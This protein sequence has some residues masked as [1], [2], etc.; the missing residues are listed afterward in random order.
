MSCELKKILSLTDQLPKLQNI[1]FVDDYCDPVPEYSQEWDGVLRNVN[2]D[3]SNTVSSS[4]KEESIRKCL[5]AISPFVDILV[6]AHLNNV[7]VYRR[8]EE[9]AHQLNGT[10]LF[11]LEPGEKIT[12]IA[13]L[14]FVSQQISNQGGLDWT[15]IILGFNSG[16]IRVY[17]ESMSLLISQKLYNEPVTCI[18]VQSFSSS[19]T[20]G[21]SHHVDGEKKVD[22]IFVFFRSTCLIIEGFTFYQTLRSCRNYLARNIGHAFAESLSTPGVS[23]RFKKWRFKNVERIVDADNCGLQEICTYDSLANRSMDRFSSLYVSKRSTQGN[24]VITSGQDPFIS[25]LRTDEND[26]STILEEVTTAVVNKV[27]NFIPG[28]L[29]TNNDKQGPKIEPPLEFYDSLEL[30]D[31]YRIGSSLTVSPSRDLIAVCDNFGRVILISL[32]DGVAIRMWKGYRDAQCGWIESQENPNDVYSRKILFLCIYAPKRG[33]LEIWRCQHGPRVEAF[34]VG[35]NCRL[36][37]CGYSMIGMNDI[38]MNQIRNNGASM[39]SSTFCY[40]F[41]YDSLS[42]SEIHAPFVCGLSGKSTVS[43]KDTLL[44]REFKS[45]ATSDESDEDKEKLAQVANLFDRMKSYEVRI[46]AILHVINLPNASLVKTLC[47]KLSKDLPLKITNKTDPKIQNVALKCRW[48]D[49]LCKLHDDFSFLNTGA[50]KVAIFN[51]VHK[52]PPDFEPQAQLLDWN[53]VDYVRCVS[54]FSFKESIFLDTVGEKSSTIPSLSEFISFFSLDQHRFSST[55]DEPADQWIS[56][57]KT[58]SDSE[59]YH[60]ISDLYQLGDFFLIPSFDEEYLE[61]CET[62]L[63]ACR[64]APSNILFAVFS[65]W[66]NSELSADW[67][68]WPKFYSYVVKIV[69][70]MKKHQST[71]QDN[72][73]SVLCTLS[74][75]IAQSDYTTSALVAA[76]ILRTVYSKHTVPDIL[77]DKSPDDESEDK[78]EDKFEKEKNK[79]FLEEWES[80]SEEKEKLSLLIKQL[81][82]CLFLTVALRS[83]KNHDPGPINLISLIQNHPGIISELVAKWIISYPLEP[84]IILSLNDYEPEDEVQDPA[85]LTFGLDIVRANDMH[86]GHEVIKHLLRK[87]R[88]HFPNSME[89]DIVLSNCTWE[90]LTLWNKDLVKNNSYLILSSKYLLNIS[91]AVLKHCIAC[92]VWKTFILKRFETLANLMEKMAKTPKDRILQRD[93]SFDEQSLLLFSNF[94]VD[95]MDSIIET[96][97]RADSEAMPLFRMDEWW[98][99]RICSN[100]QLPLVFIAIQQKPAQPELVLQIYSLV[101]VISIMI[102]FQVKN[103]KPLSLFPNDMRAML[104]GELSSS[105]KSDAVDSVINQNRM[106]FLIAATIAIAQSVPTLTKEEG[107][108][109]AKLHSQAN[110]WLHRVVTLCKDWRLDADEVR[111]RYVCELYSINCDSLA[112]EVINTVHDRE[113][114]ANEMLKTAGLRVSRLI[115]RDEEKF[116]ASI[117]PNILT[118]LRS[119]TRDSDP[120]PEVD[121]DATRLMLEYTQTYLSE[122]S[123]NQKIA[124]ELLS[125]LR[126]ILTAK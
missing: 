58:E 59:I 8:K 40:L 118:W 107:D 87:V 115:K 78:S 39:N 81:Q 93:L 18:K 57:K 12:A 122:D 88:D 37:Y 102:N 92:L 89:S 104:F 76:L 48:I 46:E 17:T 49:H 55:E 19:Y 14:P 124:Y 97:T 52:D 121:C 21:R 85:D 16:H 95:L 72:W 100:S 109:T 114:L 111:R 98:K 38:I 105:P 71:N 108:E 53:V 22:E 112:N 84:L 26:N 6:F 74:H 120:L 106:R 50:K 101:S 73:R 103:F 24:L 91:N 125:I 1:F 31:R 70:K 82:D 67:R 3:D 43:S 27:K 10:T 4:S 30:W 44:L 54:L 61:E 94:V 96:I 25:I 13:C 2:D 79:L 123:T 80:L 69:K 77:S 7:A 35:R 29:R 119:V 63:E 99:N 36:L 9:T 11:D 15:C 90:S 117:P 42:V 41:D 83:S 56:L 62:T 66:L 86:L 20:S 60:Q 116:T 28:F 65:S 68:N 32:I 34:N 126:R 110:R 5:L 45:I 75:M 113:K 33:I 64:I 51:S 23:L 47:S